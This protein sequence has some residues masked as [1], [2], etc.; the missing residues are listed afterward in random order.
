MKAFT[1]IKNRDAYSTIRGFVYQVDITILR[2]LELG[3][4]DLL[5]LEKGEDI[6]ILHGN[7]EKGKP[8]RELEQIKVRENNLTLKSDEVLES[9]LNFFLH[10]KNN[11]KLKLSF[12]F[13]TNTDYGKERPAIFLDGSSGIEVWI[14]LKN[15]E[16]LNAS[17]YLNEIKNYL[18]TSANKRIRKFTS[19]ESFD[20]QNSIE[21]W[22]DFQLFLSNSTDDEF[23]DFI[24][25][26]EWSLK[27]DDTAEIGTTIKNKLIEKKIAKN[28]DIASN[29][30]SRLFFFVFKLLC[31]KTEKE[32]CKQNLNDQTS[33][34]PLNH[35]DQIFLDYLNGLF[36]NIENRVN[37]LEKNI[38]TNNVSIE[39]LYKT[40]GN[41]ANTD[42]I[43]NYSLN[44]LPINSPSLIPTGSLRKEKVNQLINFFKEKTWI[45]LQGINGTGKSQLAVLIS[46]EYS[47]H[48]WLE[49]REYR[50]DEGKSAVM[51]EI[52][53][54]SI[55]NVKPVSD[56]VKWI[57][58]VV[59][60]IPPNSIIIFNDIPRITDNSRL[61]ELLILLSNS[62]AK[63]EIKLLTT[64]NYILN[65][66]IKNSLQKNILLEERQLEF[67]DSEIKE[68]FINNAAPEQVLNYIGLVSA[69]SSRNPRLVSAVLYYLKSIQWGE[70][71]SEIFEVL[72]NKEFTKEVI[73]DVQFSIKKNLTNEKTRE[74]LY[75]LSLIH[76]S[77]DLTEVKYVSKI[78][79]SIENPYEK[80]L[81]LINI[82]IQPQEKEM[83]QLS[84]LIQDIAN[85][86]LTEDVIKNVH[87][88]LGE[89]ILSRKKLNTINASQAIHQF[90]AGKDF[91]QAGSILMMVLNSSK[92]M[93]EIKEIQSWGYLSY[94]HNVELPKEMSPLIRSLVRFAQIRVFDILDIDSNL[95]KQQII[96]SLD[97]PNLSKI[98]Q[99]TINL[100]SCHYVLE[101]DLSKFWLLFNNAMNALL[102]FEKENNKIFEVKVIS[103]LLWLCVRKL[104]SSID[105]NKWFETIEALEFNFKIDFFNDPI[106]DTSIAIMNNDIVSLENKK[107]DIDI[108]WDEVIKRMEILIFHF[109]KRKQESL[110]AITLRE[111]LVCQFERL[112]K[113]KETIKT[114][115]SAINGFVLDESKYLIYDIIAR[116]LYNNKDI[117]ASVPWFKKAIEINCENNLHYIDTLIYYASAIS[118][119]NSLKSIEYLL[120]AVQIAEKR[121][122][123]DELDYIRLLGELAIAYWVDG[124]YVQ[125]FECFEN[126]LSK[127]FEYKKDNPGERW[128]RLFKLTGHSL[129]FISSILNEEEVRKMKDGAD[130][131]EP[132]QGM[133]FF[134]NKDFSHLYDSSNDPISMALLANCAEGVNNL[135]KAY[136]WS[137]KAFDLA[138]KNGNERII[139]TISAV[140]SQYSLIN[141]KIEEAFESR[142]LFAAISTCLK[143]E[144]KE[145]YEKSVGM[146][147]TEILDK[148]PSENWNIAEDLTVFYAIIPMFIMVLTDQ[149]QDSKEK[150]SHFDNFLNLLINYEI[151][152][153]NQSQWS[154]VEELSRKIVTNAITE[155]ILIGRSN[156]FGEIGKKQ[157]QIIC[158][159]GMIF[160]G[161]DLNLIVM[162]L[163]NIIPYF[164]KVFKKFSNHSILKYVVVP[165]VKA[166]CT[167]LVEKNFVGS[168]SDLEKLKLGIEQ[169]ENKNEHA[170]QFTIQ[171]IVQEFEIN[172]VGN[173][174]L[175]LYEFQEI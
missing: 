37:E 35:S 1:E 92:T 86:N 117:S 103:N 108:N 116:L 58:G 63:K 168:N 33:N 7:I 56:R 50:E 155:K 136:T 126:V 91:N 90:V 51:I 24:F 34:I 112:K 44:N 36:R 146:K 100:F 5:V 154:V 16:L 106:A 163:L 158:I 175:W 53:L 118:T 79:E 26:F 160:M 148:K 49:L 71:S 98:E 65:D 39:N 46:K 70:D 52:F 82:W 60:S 145:K 66:R 28:L 134:N 129:G 127:L 132:Y 55:S 59:N 105:I 131:F 149:L 32:L 171:L 139:I 68:Y 81:E 96:N 121:E 62:L 140:C 172:I 166:I 75:R 4:N 169:I 48:W 22:R 167:R 133:Y 85:Y 17:E 38:E 99:F 43:F 125:S 135:D 73:E 54:T 122:K 159:L 18:R 27:N 107:A 147:F 102:A 61:K 30:Y 115:S 153:S 45:A 110:E 128:I 72:L 69:I 138:R 104:E 19:K 170:T 14:K 143:G 29:F 130:F 67:S 141:F 137:L 88:A 78:N 76:G 21:N 42:A 84:P 83:Y 94:W 114:A 174:K 161:K 165:F 152:A 41:L 12:R 25:S 9:I 89:A 173:K 111:V 80:L 77:F 101:T 13:I 157:E 113:K 11:P 3:E 15:R 23:N 156:T 47:Q 40:V 57:N 31:K 8:L 120:K 87:L 123:F 119:K 2:W 162:Q 64:S 97:E 10:R 144:A 109:K 93:E 151:Q 150:D 95:Y 20:K 142:L 74:L 124:N 164:T 6:D